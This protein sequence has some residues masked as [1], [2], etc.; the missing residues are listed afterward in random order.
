MN[1][2]ATPYV[3]DVVSEASGQSAEVV[4]LDREVAD[5]DALIA[6]LRTTI[7]MLEGQVAAPQSALVNHATEIEILK[8]RLFGPK[9]SSPEESTQ[10]RQ[11]A[12]AR[13]AASTFAR[14]LSKEWAVQAKG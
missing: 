5:R 1:A 8:R 6:T 13:I 4:V 11:A 14:T 12:T 10:A 3:E 2:L 7:T 9:Y